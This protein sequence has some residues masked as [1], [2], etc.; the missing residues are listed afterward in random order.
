MLLPFPLA[1]APAEAPTL[2]LEVDSRV[3]FSNLKKIP[4]RVHVIGRDVALQGVR[5]VGGGSVPQDGGP[6]LRLTAFTAKEQTAVPVILTKSGEGKDRVDQ[7]VELALVL[8]VPDEER[9]Q[10]V[11]K[12]L[13]R[14]VEEAK[15][16]KSSTAAVYSSPNGQAAMAN[17]LKG[18]YFQNRTGKFILKAEF[19]ATLAG[20]KVRV[21]AEPKTIEVQYRGEFFDQPG[22]Q[23]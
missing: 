15:T 10:A 22:F 11:K 6:V 8:P 4:L 14:L 20:Q 2:S 12:Y 21:T 5:V 1:F 23:K 16:E 19:S 17:T 7:Y 3:P 9:D 13:A 18:L